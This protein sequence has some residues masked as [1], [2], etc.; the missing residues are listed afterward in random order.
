[1]ARAATVTEHLATHNWVEPSSSPSLLR[2][3]SLL[4]FLFQ[5]FQFLLHHHLFLLL[6]ELGEQEGDLQPH[7]PRRT[8]R[9]GDGVAVKLCAEVHR[10]EPQLHDS[11]NATAEGHRPYIAAAGHPV[12][13]NDGLQGDVIPLLQVV[14]QE[15]LNQELIDR[16]TAAFT[17]HRPHIVGQ[18]ADGP[19]PRLRQHNNARPQA[20][21]PLSRNVAG[22]RGNDERRPNAPDQFA[23]LGGREEERW[24]HVTQPIL[25][26][27][28]L[29]RIRLPYDR[30]N[31]ARDQVPILADAGGYDWLNV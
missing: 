30:L 26:P 14:V 25:A 17:G 29:L 22:G 8:T 15:V 21:L 11:S 13:G 16:R 18:R 31:N 4:L 9:G 5:L 12:G 1:M 7:A 19:V 27:G 10:L 23:R 3:R 2:W 6:G 28:R 20:E 24:I